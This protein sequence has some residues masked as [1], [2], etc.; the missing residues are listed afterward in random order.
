MAFEA[1]GADDAGVAAA[2]TGTGEGAGIAAA[3]ATASVARAAAFAAV[4]ARAEVRAQLVEAIQAFHALRAQVQRLRG[5]VPAVSPQPVNVPN[6]GA[7]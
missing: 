2:A 3:A 5:D 4:V 6:G 1:A 7:R